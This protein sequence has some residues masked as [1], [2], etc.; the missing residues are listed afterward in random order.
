MPIKHTENKVMTPEFRLCFPA[1]FEPKSFDTDTS[2]NANAKYSMVMVFPKSADISALKEAATAAILAKWPDKASRPKNLKSPFRDGSEKED[3]EGFGSET[4]FI[5]ASTKSRP[6]IVDQKRQP[7]FDS[8][9]IYA[10]CY[11][12]ATIV[13]WAYDKA[14]NRGVSFWINNVQKLR[15]GESLSGR[16]AAENDFDA[17]EEAD[18]FE[19]GSE[20]SGDDLFG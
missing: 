11:C 19:D 1:L 18:P 5:A 17:T 14:G 10:G 7:I 9:E 3:W 16:V 20:K 6:G 8:N 4:I 2:Q 13:P 15:D 12:R